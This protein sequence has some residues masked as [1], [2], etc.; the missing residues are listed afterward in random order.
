MSVSGK[1]F[2]NIAEN[3]QEQHTEIGYRMAV[4]R[5]Y[6]SMYHSVK[7]ILQSQI[8]NYKDGGVHFKLTEHLLD[9]NNNEPHDRTKLKS[10]CYKLRQGKEFRCEADYNLN[11]TQMNL[12]LSEQQL[13]QAKRVINTC[14]ELSTAAA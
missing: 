12:E 1:D 3:C 2:L 8:P 6:Y 14:S 11:S 7:D 13:A 4:G 5:S 9:A 10:L